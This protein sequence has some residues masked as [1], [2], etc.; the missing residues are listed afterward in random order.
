MT[1]E[2][3]NKLIAHYEKAIND[4][5]GMGHLQAQRY[6]A[7]NG[8][9][10]GV[11]SCAKE[12]FENTYLYFSRWVNSFGSRYWF[13]IPM[14]ATSAAQA[15]ELLQLRLNRLKTFTDGK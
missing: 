3:C 4:M 8:L 9:L 6:L 15:I 1:Q 13:E 12:V 14:N 2:L 11:C 10:N 5:Q 7:N